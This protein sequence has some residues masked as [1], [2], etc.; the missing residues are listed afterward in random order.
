LAFLDPCSA[1]TSDLQKQ[2]QH[3]GKARAAQRPRASSRRTPPAALTGSWRS[4]GRVQQSRRIKGLGSAGRYFGGMKRRSKTVPKARS[5]SSA[6]RT[7]RPDALDALVTAA[8]Q[9]LALPIDPAW[10]GSIKFNLQLALTMA[11]RVDEFP[12]PDMIDPAPVFHA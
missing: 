12:L 7:G 2:G 5:R 11:A 8:A 9:A 3:S 1:I 4:F 10:H 6:K